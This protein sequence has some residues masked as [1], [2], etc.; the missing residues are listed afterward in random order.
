MALLGFTFSMLA[1][2]DAAPSQ[3]KCLSERNGGVWLLD[4]CTLSWLFSGRIDRATY[5][6]IRGTLFGAG[7]I[8]I[9]PSLVHPQ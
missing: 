9:W 6:P 7:R 3:R 5:L 8:L 4:R 2:S 1:A